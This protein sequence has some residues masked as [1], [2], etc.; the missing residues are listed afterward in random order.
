[1]TFDKQRPL[2]KAYDIRGKELLFSDDFICA[3]SVVFANHYKAYGNKLTLGFDVRPKSRHIGQIF[4]HTFQRF[5]IDVHFVGLATTPLVAYASQDT[6]GNGIMITASHSPKDILGIKWLTQGQSPTPSQIV[7]IFDQLQSVPYRNLYDNSDTNTTSVNLPAPIDTYAKQYAGQI[8]AIF[9][10]LNTC[11]QPKTLIIDCLNGATGDLATAIFDQLSTVGYT[12]IMLNN[13][14]DGSYPKGDPNPAKPNRLTELC[15]AVK[16]HKADLGFAFDGD[17]DRLAVVD[18]L[19][20]VVAFDWLILL[21]ANCAFAANPTKNSVLYDVKCT[22]CLKNTLTQQGLKPLISQ[23]GSS[24]LRHAITHNSQLVFAGELS[25]HFIFN[26]GLFISHDDGLY[27]A[28]R[29][30]AFLGN[31]K[32]SD[33]IDGLPSYIATPDIYIDMTCAKTWIEHFSTHLQHTPAYQ[34]KYPNSQFCFVDG[35]RLDNNKGFGLIRASNTS[36]S[37]TVRFAADDK[38]AFDEIIDTFIAL[39]NDLPDDP[40]KSLIDQLQRFKL[41][42]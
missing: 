27:A 9:D 2:F 31:Q 5:G 40:P 8:L 34:M 37:L 29:L 18:N 10:K 12:V 42:V 19:G 4:Y 7:A 3:L 15:Q 26:D 35:I 20:H 11:H 13:Q 41:S 24:H 21:L 39:L 33:V 14:P 23:T 36:D 6:K 1:M 32:L 28:M 22:H 16:Q 38:M 30:L 17:G 25:G